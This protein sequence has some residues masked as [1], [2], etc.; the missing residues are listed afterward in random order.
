M[1]FPGDVLAIEKMES[2][3]LEELLLEELRRVQRRKEEALRNEAFEEF[4]YW[5][6]YAGA[7]YDVLS[8]LRRRG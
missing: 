6:G 8:L 7:I 4:Y 5:S 3:G 2:G 1:V